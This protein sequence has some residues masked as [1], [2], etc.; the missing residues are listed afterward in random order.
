LPFTLYI[1]EGAR[2]TRKLDAAK[3][4]TIQEKVNIYNIFMHYEKWKES[5][6]AYDFNDVVNHVIS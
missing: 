3:F 6:K 2:S 5:M 1:G 4:L